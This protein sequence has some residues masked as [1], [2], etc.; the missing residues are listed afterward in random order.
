MKHFIFIAVVAV[1]LTGY[2]SPKLSSVAKV[3]NIDLQVDVKMNSKKFPPN[4]YVTTTPQLLSF[5]ITNLDKDNIFYPM[6]KGVSAHGL[7]SQ[8][9]VMLLTFLLSDKTM[10]EHKV[11]LNS[12][13]QVSPLITT[14]EQPMIIN[15]PSDKKIKKLVSI[16]VNYEDFN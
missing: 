3:D 7:D 15:L 4:P 11:E 9:A 14:T 10:I 1:I 8:K 2:S 12:I 16:K 13:P 5:S 6:K